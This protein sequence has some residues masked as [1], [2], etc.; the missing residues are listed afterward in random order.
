MH[1]TDGAPGGGE[2]RAALLGGDG[3]CVEA[4]GSPRLDVPEVT[5][6]SVQQ[7][8]QHKPVQKRRQTRAIIDLFF[9]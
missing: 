8:N 3:E 1:L 6:P 2:L 5:S 9:L 4:G 7:T